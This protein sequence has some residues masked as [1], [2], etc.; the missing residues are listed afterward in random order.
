MFNLR[1]IYKKR[2]NWV[3]KGNF[4]KLLIIAG[5]RKYTGSPWYNAMA[6]LRSG[7]D[8]VYIITPESVANI[9]SSV[10]PE[11]LT[12][13]YHGDFLTQN[14]VHLALSTIQ[15][16]RIT[17]LLVGSG[18]GRTEETLEAIQ[19]IIQKVNLPMVLDADAIRAL[20]DNWKILT[21][22][23]ALLTPH[24]NEFKELTNEE[25]GIDF[26]DRTKKVKDWA[27]K[28]GTTILLKGYRDI[29][30][31]GSALYVNRTGSS[32][33]TKGGFGDTLAGICGALLSRGIDPL[34]AAC[35]GAYINGKAGEL[36][37]RE[38]GEGVIASD[39]F[40][41]IPKVIK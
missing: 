35:A 29:I 14:Q 20:K 15:E 34:Q 33:M 39:I 8:L 30:S 25:I 31:D 3:H 4:G 10:A 13:G 21:G 37:S 22:K 11:L 19:A 23:R 26:A 38:F 18:L 27:K 32:C 41:F 1:K 12:V 16:R 6:A 9:L 2:D 5:S 17:A 24:A 40:E 7:V 28:I 36:A